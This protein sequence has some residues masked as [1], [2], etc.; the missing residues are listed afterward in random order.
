MTNWSGPVGDSAVL[1]RSA[2]RPSSKLDRPV[3]VLHPLCADGAKVSKKR[4]RGA[5]WRAGLVH[6]GRLRASALATGPLSSY[7][8]P[9]LAFPLG[10]SSPAEIFT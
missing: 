6:Q 2:V 1:F 8:S 9:F 7:A 3:S 10:A 4:C 5:G